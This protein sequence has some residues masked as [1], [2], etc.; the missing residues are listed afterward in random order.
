MPRMFVVL[1]LFLPNILFAHLGDDMQRMFESI[2]VSS[3]V[4]N[5]DV[6][7]GQEGKFAYGGGM[8]VRSPGTEIQPI[9]V[10]APIIGI[11][12][13]SFDLH[14]GG[15]GFIDSKKFVEM[16]RNIGANSAG[17]L[18][19]LGLQQLSPAISNKIE[20]IQN[21]ADNFN[22]FNINSCEMSK[23]FV[24][25]TIDV[26]QSNQKRT[27]EASGVMS[28]SNRWGRTVK[29]REACQK[30]EN[31]K[32]A[33]TPETIN[34]SLKDTTLYNKNIAWDVINKSP[35]LRE[36]DLDTKQLLM[37][38]TGTIVIDSDG[39]PVSY[40]SLLDLKINN[41]INGMSGHEALNLYTCDESKKCLN[42]IKAQVPVDFNNF[43]EFVKK[44]VRS[45]ED[46]VKNDLE[47]SEADKDFIAKNN[48]KVYKMIKLQTI[49]NSNAISFVS[50]HIRLISKELILQ[51]MDDCINNVLT[52]YSGNLLPKALNDDF[53]SLVEKAK[54]GLLHLKTE[55][56]QTMRIMH[57]IDTKISMMEKQVTATVSDQIFTKS[58]WST[59]VGD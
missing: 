31:V 57:D 12:D 23:Y 59:R 1:L 49:Y 21:M 27:C 26:I 15:F 7:K 5:A 32:A 39:N 18:F 53:L 2:G 52:A 30:I 11:N 56:F 9:R 48:Y 4:T 54:E 14:L 17:Y 20:S 42:I 47:L 3:N 8:S 35:S 10:Q 19:S 45:I 44:R 25:S 36:L 38:L 41:I 24:N 58:N 51:Y 13:C 33:T 55:D 50:E 6:Y 34:D 29:A 22:R 28:G 37:S 46:T 16:A 43:Y 40:P